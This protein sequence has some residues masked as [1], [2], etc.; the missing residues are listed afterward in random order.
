MINLLVYLF[1]LPLLV[2]FNIQ[3]APTP[4]PPDKIYRKDSRP[5]ST[6]FREGF[7][8]RGHNVNLLSHLR[9]ISVWAQSG[10]QASGFISTTSDRDVARDFQPQ[11]PG[12]VYEIVPPSS[13]YDAQLSLEHGIEQ[14]PEGSEERTSWEETLRFTQR[15][16]QQQWVVTDRIRPGRIAGAYQIIPNPQNPSEP[17]LGTFIPNVNFDQYAS[18]SASNAYYP[19]NSELP[20]YF[21]YVRT[22]MRN[23]LRSL[24]FS[25]L[26]VQGSNNRSK[27][28][29]SNICKEPEID[30]EYVDEYSPGLDLNLVKVIDESNFDFGNS[31]QAWK[32][33]NADGL[34]DHCAIS[35]HQIV[36]MI[37]N[38]NNG[39][40]KISQ[41]IGDA[42]WSDSRYWVDFNGDGIIDYCRITDTWTR[43]QCNEGTESG[44]FKNVIIS[45]NIDA[46]WVSTRRW[47]SIDKSG[48]KSFCRQVRQ[49]G[50]E[51]AIRC[52]SPSDNFQDTYMRDFTSGSA[53]YDYGYTGTQIWGDVNGDRIDDFCFI[54]GSGSYTLNCLIVEGED[55]SQSQI[56]QAK[57]DHWPQSFAII[58]INNDLKSDYCFTVNGK[59]SCRINNKLTLSSPSP[60]I[61]SQLN[62]HLGTWGDINNDGF[63]DLCHRPNN[64]TVSCFINGG[65]QALHLSFSKS[66]SE[67]NTGSSGQFYYPVMSTNTYCTK[68][69][70]NNKCYTLNTPRV[71]SHCEVLV[72]VSEKWVWQLEADYLEKA[73][74][75]NNNHCSEPGGICRR[76][77]Y[78]R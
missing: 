22:E 50:S 11:E 26:G 33:F 72:Y 37:Q 4:T 17:Q 36:C 45:S 52:I 53:R 29:D 19:V 15:L 46:G 68:N 24:A 9:G 10:M 7:L 8:P 74:C 14:L 27:R 67:L 65:N 71:D 58:D 49:Y 77:H 59:I 56:F 5:P 31:D 43:L 32:D 76:W 18:P 12:Y 16:N 21:A 73:S 61:G 51:M 41:N 48:K 30:I 39:F 62:A 57:L 70:S 54:T 23:S 63:I 3:A 6:I 66:F 40:D 69:G 28:S 42:G 75:E 60:F 13:T 55:F 44:Y 34:I 35:H 20:S 25:C 47:A 2:S 38:K 64:K 1:L 78:F